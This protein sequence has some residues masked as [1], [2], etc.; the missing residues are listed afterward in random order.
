MHCKLPPSFFFEDCQG[1]TKLLSG[2]RIEHYLDQ[3]CFVAVHLYWGVFEEILY[4]EILKY[5]S[6]LAVLPRNR[7]DPNC[8]FA[9]NCM[10]GNF[11]KEVTNKIEPGKHQNFSLQ[12]IVI[13]VKGMHF[14]I[15][16][17][18]LWCCIWVYLKGLPEILM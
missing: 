11:T 16:T 14:E 18:Q 3:V 4:W 8:V 17:M 15:S 2:E 5:S 6:L 1:I 13:L 10:N 9:V 7:F 12:G